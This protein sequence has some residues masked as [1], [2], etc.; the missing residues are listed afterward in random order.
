MRL[1]ETTEYRSAGTVEFLVDDDTGRF[2]FL[3]VSS[4]Q[5]S[6]FPPIHDVTIGWELIIMASCQMHIFYSGIACKS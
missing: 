2:Y 3:E 1:G 4:V 6:R 5:A